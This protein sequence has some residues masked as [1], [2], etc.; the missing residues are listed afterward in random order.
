EEWLDRVFIEKASLISVE[1]DEK[2]W[3]RL[4]IV[5]GVKSMDLRRMKISR[6]SHK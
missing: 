3:K 5:D 2:Y 4:E 1:Y 6:N